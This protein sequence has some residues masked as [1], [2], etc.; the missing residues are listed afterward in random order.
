VPSAS[1][2]A[3]SPAGVQ[4]QFVDLRME[5]AEDGVRVRWQDGEREAY[6]VLRSDRPDAWREAEKT[7]VTDRQWT[8]PAPKAGSRLTYYRVET[9]RDSW[10]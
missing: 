6:T 10:H 7:L 4:A 1:V 2:E 9:V 5:K 3:V 8:E